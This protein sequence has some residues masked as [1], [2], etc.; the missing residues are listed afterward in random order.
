MLECIFHT[1]QLHYDYAYSALSVY[2]H[3]VCRH[4]VVGCA[5]NLCIWAAR[6][7]DLI[8]KFTVVQGKEREFS[9]T[10]TM[11]TMNYDD[12]LFVKKISG[13]SVCC[14][15]YSPDCAQLA[16]G[17]STGEVQVF[18]IACSSSIFLLPP[19]KVT[20]TIA[21]HDFLQYHDHLVLRMLNL[22]LIVLALIINFA[23]IF[24]QC[25][26][27]VSPATAMA[28]SEDGKRFTVGHRNGYIQIWEGIYA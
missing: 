4:L 20:T 13:A 27:E 17:L 8:H 15:C 24:F 26:Q 9:T 12:C 5:G 21:H 16:A 28:Y 2:D 3:P 14:L 1:T 18:E 10:L 23:K 19:P 22:T 7:G 6:T 25:V 11:L